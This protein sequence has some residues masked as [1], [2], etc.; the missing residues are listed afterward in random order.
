MLDDSSG[1]KQKQ[2]PTS[3][4]PVNSSQ[5]NNL[6]LCIIIMCVGATMVFARSFRVEI[7]CE[8][9]AKRCRE[10]IRMFFCKTF[11]FYKLILLENKFLLTPTLKKKEICSIISLLNI[12]KIQVT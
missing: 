6:N 11:T 12:E 10:K 9:K 5:M 2:T 4:R 3:A 8:M 1:T 7:F